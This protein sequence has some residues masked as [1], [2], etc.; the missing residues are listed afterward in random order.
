MVGLEP[1]SP[2]PRV[3][4]DKA[5]RGRADERAGAT[6]THEPVRVLAL[7]R[8]RRPAV[9]TMLG[10]SRSHG[11]AVDTMLA[12]QRG[13]GNAYVSRYVA[14]LPLSRAPQTVAPPKR[15]GMPKGTTELLDT[16]AAYNNFLGALSRVVATRGGLAG[17]WELLDE[18]EELIV[19][20]RR[21]L[22]LGY[23]RQT[24]GPALTLW[25]SASPR[26]DGE[27]AIARQAG[28]PPG[29]VDAAAAQLRHVRSTV[30]GGAY[31][32]A[33]REAL[34]G[35]KFEQPDLV[36]VEA[37]LKRAEQKYKQ[38]QALADK[39]KPLLGDAAGMTIGADPG[40]GKAVYDVVSLPGSIS[41]K[42]EYA[43]K[44]GVVGKTATALDLLGVIADTA[45]NTVK[46]SMTVAAR[47][48]RAKQAAAMSKGLLAEAKG[49]KAAATRFDMLAQK[50]EV[51]GKAANVL[52]I[53]AEG[54]KLVDALLKSPV[55]WDTVLESG[56]E[57]LLNTA[58]LA[59]GADGAP[60][61]VV[62]MV[63]RAEIEV[64]RMVSDQIK[65]AKRETARGAAAD[66]IGV[67]A[68]I[69]KRQAADFVADCEVAV[70]G[71]QGAVREIAA[72]KVLQDAPKLAKSLTAL[73]SHVARK[74]K[75]SIGGYP[76]MVEALG[77]EAL[78]YFYD[79]AP[80][81]DPLNVAQ[82]CAAIFAGCNALARHVQET[83]KD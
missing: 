47:V 75:D 24:W 16:E 13:A 7:H 22:Q 17:S 27:L 61:L 29:H 20:M 78:R 52:A 5:S 82:Q 12:L 41:D 50:L 72:K 71:Q 49:F 74:A 48:Q 59:L 26:F 83:Y 76:K 80:A 63:I 57:I 42:L 21:V 3:R 36:H 25:E 32:E 1:T 66:F 55:D 18:H 4:S 46:V 79:A 67:A 70:N 58:E 62:V 53:L 40:F 56:T 15:A 6:P 68:K 14:R 31:H 23:E 35:N 11:L 37:Q 19:L 77:P 60:I 39:M 54:T 73:N 44:N 81:E 10:L 64:L 69:A 38:S 43:K 8:A 30:E 9:D 34:A 33:H 65:W 28:V 51:A 2:R 45:D